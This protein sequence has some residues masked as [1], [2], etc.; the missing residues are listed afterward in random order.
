MLNWRKCSMVTDK[1]LNNEMTKEE[2]R[3]SLEAQFWNDKQE[4]YKNSKLYKKIEK[5]CKNIDF[6]DNK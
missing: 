2:K 1:N 3:S 4:V 5:V 6:K